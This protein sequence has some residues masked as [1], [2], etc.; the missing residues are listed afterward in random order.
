VDIAADHLPR[1]HEEDEV[2]IVVANNY[3]DRTVDG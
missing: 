1:M 2:S 3:V